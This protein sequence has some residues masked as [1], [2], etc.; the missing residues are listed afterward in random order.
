M[1]K[2]IC[3]KQDICIVLTEICLHKWQHT[4]VNRS[5]FSLVFP[6]ITVYWWMDHLLGCVCC[7]NHIDKRK[8]YKVTSVLMLWNWQFQS[9]KYQC[10]IRIS[11]PYIFSVWNWNN[12]E[13]FFC[14][15]YSRF[16]QLLIYLFVSL[17]RGWAGAP[18]RPALHCACISL[19]ISLI[20]NKI[21]KS[22]KWISLYILY[23]MDTLLL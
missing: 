10:F 4:F 1:L 3:K 17:T 19:R 23:L 2:Q 7:S 21:G 8:V 14:M 12:W 22:P 9:P 16:S 11:V 6:Q 20:K 18:E 13:L 5:S 15:E